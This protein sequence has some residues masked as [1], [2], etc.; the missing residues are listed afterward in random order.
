VSEPLAKK[1]RDDFFPKALIW[2]GEIKGL[3][4]LM[5]EAVTLKFIPGPLTKQQQAELMQIQAAAKR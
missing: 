4:S 3:D 2:P 5:E 1:V